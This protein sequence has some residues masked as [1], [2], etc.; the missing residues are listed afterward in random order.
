MSMA[1][2]RL[3]VAKH[4]E[5]CEPLREMA[6]SGAL[7]D[8]VEIIDIESDEGF[9]KLTD[10]EL[11][12]VP[13]IYSPGGKC[14]VKYDKDNNIIDIVCPGVEEELSETPED[15]SLA[16]PLVDTSPEAE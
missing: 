14:E 1:K 10:L 15:A 3:L 16:P 5:P 6:E 8:N 9:A 12:E 11:T 13:S 4:C 7:G 2:I